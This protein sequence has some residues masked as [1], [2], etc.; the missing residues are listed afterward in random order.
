[1]GFEDIKMERQGQSWT[2]QEQ[3]DLEHELKLN[4]SFDDIARKHK[5]SNLA[6][7]LRFARRS[8]TER[9]LRPAFFI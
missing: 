4:M 5:R 2:E 7:R 6:I 9:W 8:N 1:M 3:I